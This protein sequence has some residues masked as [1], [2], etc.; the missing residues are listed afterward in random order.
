MPLLSSSRG[1]LS[2]TNPEVD[3][4]YAPPF[5]ATM[6]YTL[7]RP[8]APGR[9]STDTLVSIVV[10][11]Y[12]EEAVLPLLFDR[13]RSVLAS[14]DCRYEVLFVD[15]GSTDGTWELLCDAIEANPTWKAVR[16]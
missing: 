1:S 2:C 5:E 12:N 8:D 3:V 15:D 9:L 14:W 10:P 4:L 7:T 11:C 6:P 16:L 13:L